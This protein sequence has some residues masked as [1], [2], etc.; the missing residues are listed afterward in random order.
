MTKKH[1]RKSSKILFVLLLSAIVLGMLLEYEFHFWSNLPRG[2]GLW[3]IPGFEGAKCQLVGARPI[4]PARSDWTGYAQ[5]NSGPVA[6]KVITSHDTGLAADKVVWMNSDPFNTLVSWDYQSADTGNKVDRLEMLIETQQQI[7]LSNL[8]YMGDPLSWNDTQQLEVVQY[9]PNQDRQLTKVV[10]GDETYYTLTKKSILLVPAEMHVTLSI[11][12]ANDHS[13]HS[14]GWQEGTW[15]PIEIWFSLD[16][17]TWNTLTSSYASE[18]QLSEWEASYFATNPATAYN[19]YS[20]ANVKGGFPI[21]GWVQG[22]LANVGTDYPDDYDYEIWKQ[23]ASSGG[24]STQITENSKAILDALTQTFPQLGG[25]ALPLFSNPADPQEAYSGGYTGFVNILEQARIYPFIPSQVPAYFVITVNTLG[26]YAESTGIMSWNL[27]YPAVNY[28]FRVIYAVYGEF[29][30][31]WTV[32]TAEDNGYPGW[33]TRTYQ[34]VP[35][36]PGWQWLTDLFT[37]PIFLFFFILFIIIIIV[38][39]VAIFAPWVITGLSRTAGQ[40][41]RAYREGYE[42]YDSG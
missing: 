41:R 18:D 36:V 12:A 16:F 27:Y 21:A 2:A 20:Q 40:T 13:T 26:T 5:Y 4:D 29:T 8:N 10:N 14:S 42:Q 25:R 31:L 24:S 6:G 11:P 30:Y 23:Q 9:Q 38:I 33:E 1:R 17:T 22:Y 7:A 39:L 37:N 19:E 35:I 28:R 32:N 15:F 3:I 34:W